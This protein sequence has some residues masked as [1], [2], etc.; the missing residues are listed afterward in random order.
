MYPIYTPQ[1]CTH[2]H[3]V[4]VCSGHTMSCKYNTLAIIQT[5][6]KL[7]FFFSK[8]LICHLWD[9][10]K[11]DPYH[12]PNF[13]VLYIIC[14]FHSNAVMTWIWKNVQHMLQCVQQVTVKHTLKL[15]N[16]STETVICAVVGN[17][18]PNNITVLQLKQ[19]LSNKY[20]R[21]CTLTAITTTF[22]P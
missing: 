4:T 6:Y 11:W 15:N 16:A 1:F 19:T 8:K 18:S 5:G 10:R 13:L 3:V 9:K 7:H 21:P 12:L 17:Y 14:T 20:S 2:R 22:I